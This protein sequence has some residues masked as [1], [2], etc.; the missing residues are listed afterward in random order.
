M[1]LP[2][3]HEYLYRLQN[4]ETPTSTSTPLPPIVQNISKVA[5]TVWSHAFR[6]VPL[7]RHLLPPRNQP[8][9]I[10]QQAY[11]HNNEKFEYANPMQYV[12]HST[13]S[14]HVNH[15]NYDKQF[16][17]CKRTWT[18]EEDLLL[19]KYA[20]MYGGKRWAVIANFIPNRNAKQ[21]RDRWKILRLKN[22]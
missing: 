6:F 7:R 22:C 9:R 8:R 14:N 10:V 13:H 18:R 19:Q 1:E 12:N 4:K 2:P 20:T 17:R 21:C 15:S 11:V 5:S 3:I 16:K